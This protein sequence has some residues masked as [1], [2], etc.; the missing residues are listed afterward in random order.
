[1]VTQSRSGRK[2]LSER[3]ALNTSFLESRAEILKR[4]IVEL[5]QNHRNAECPRGVFRRKAA[6]NS[7]SWQD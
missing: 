5:E 1:M 6:Q 2:T 7:V 4:W 3:T